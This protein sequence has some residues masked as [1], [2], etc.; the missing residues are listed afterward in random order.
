MMYILALPGDDDGKEEHKMQCN[1]SLL[2]AHD[3]L[4]KDAEFAS[5]TCS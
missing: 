5:L 1:A 2:T 3:L 4:R